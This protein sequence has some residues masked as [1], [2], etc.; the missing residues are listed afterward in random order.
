[1]NGPEWLSTERYDIVAKLPSGAK[2]EQVGAMWQ[3]LLAERFG[4]TL[5]HDSNE[6][7]VEDLVVGKRG[8]KL[9]DTAEDVSTPAADGP[10]KMKDGQ[11]AGPGVVVILFPGPTPKAHMMAKAKPISKLTASL[12]NQLNRPVIDK[13]GLTGLYDFTLDFAPRASV[14]L[15]SGAPGSAAGAADAEPDPDLPTALQQQL[16]L[17]LVASKAG[18][19]VLIIDKAVKV[20]TA[21]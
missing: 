3:N 6:F 20:P 5:H 11:L 19:D 13:T 16:G 18:L 21:N 15:P 7:Q 17:K 10:P 12:S 14:P 8:P 9:K 2:K 1:M 4:L